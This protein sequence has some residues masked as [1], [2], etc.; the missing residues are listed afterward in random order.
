[1]TCS[2]YIGPHDNIHDRIIEARVNKQIDW[3]QFYGLE[4]N[5][6]RDIILELLDLFRTSKRV[7]KD[8]QFNTCRDTIGDDGDVIYVRAA[9]FT[10]RLT[11]FVELPGY[12]FIV[13][14]LSAET[15]DYI[16]R[17]SASIRS[18]SSKTHGFYR[19]CLS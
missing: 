13:V 16:T 17:S 4:F 3:M 10:Q 9:A 7:W 11:S 14:Q 15:L 12:Y 6:S 19:I 8:I 1:M 18:S 5:I 2:L